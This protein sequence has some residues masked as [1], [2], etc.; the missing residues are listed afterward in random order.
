MFGNTTT[1]GNDQFVINSSGYT[2]S[3]NKLHHMIY[4]NLYPGK[5]HLINSVY[6]KSRSNCLDLGASYLINGWSTFA[7]W[8]YNQNMYTH[9]IKVI[10]GKVGTAFLTHNFEKGYM[11]AYNFLLGILPKAD[12]MQYLIYM[13]QYPGLVESYIFGAIATEESINKGFASSPQG[14]LSK[15]REVNLGDFFFEYK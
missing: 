3:L 1:G 5:G 7:M 11:R 4:L 14:L 2:L 12:A 15:Y 9:N 8:H 13:T 6:S 10:C